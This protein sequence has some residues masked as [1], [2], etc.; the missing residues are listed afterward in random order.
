MA[1][2]AKW[3]GRT[4]GSP[5]HPIEL[6]RSVAEAACVPGVSVSK[7]AL[8]HG[9]NVNMVFRWR[10]MFRAGQFGAPQVA[11]APLLL[12]LVV[13]APAVEESVAVPQTGK[14]CEQPKASPAGIMRLRLAKGQVS[15]E[16]RVDPAVLRII[17]WIPL[18]PC[19]GLSP[20][21]PTEG[22]VMLE[23]YFKYRRVIARFRTGALGNEIDGIAA[24]LSRAGYKRGLAKLHLARIARFS[25]Y[26]T[27]CGCSK[28][29]PIPPQT[30]IAIYG[31]DRQRPHAGLHKEQSALQ[32]G[33]FR[34]GLQSN[35]PRTTRTAH[36]LPTICN[37]CVSFAACV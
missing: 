8:E 11:D 29:T 1:S 2:V 35:R 21:F 13:G 32:R 16:D 19:R 36:C 5:N 34:S 6:K 28:S 25:A 27:G 30:S 4:H 33:A 12:P 17:I 37:T 9:L 14:P 15:I 23:L 3:G 31:Q 10:R 7:L 24:D 22:V 20:A 18:S 26:A